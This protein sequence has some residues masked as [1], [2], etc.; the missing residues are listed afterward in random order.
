MYLDRRYDATPVPNKLARATVGSTFDLVKWSEVLISQ[1]ASNYDNAFRDGAFIGDYSNV[2][3]ATDGTV[4]A[5]WTGV[6][7][8][9]FDSDI[10]IAIFKVSS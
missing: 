3:I 9:K 6:T 5:V 8:G 4:Y 10:F 1:F 7:P 2:L